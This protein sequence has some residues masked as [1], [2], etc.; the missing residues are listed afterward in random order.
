MFVFKA[1]ARKRPHTASLIVNIGENATFE[2]IY[3]PSAPQR[4]QANLKITVVDNEYEDS[5][6]QMIG[7][8]FQDDITLDNIGSAFISSDLE[9][10]IAVLPDDDVPGRILYSTTGKFSSHEN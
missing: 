1:Q 8:G 4:S 10:E 3:R 5:I 7:E 9:D 2:V 6:I